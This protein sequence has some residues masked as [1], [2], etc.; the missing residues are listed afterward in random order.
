MSEHEKT[1][2]VGR[3]IEFGNS[4]LKRIHLSREADRFVSARELLACNI[5]DSH[6]QDLYNI[7]YADR[8]GL[9]TSSYI[10]TINGVSFLDKDEVQSEV[11]SIDDVPKYK[12]GDAQCTAERLLSVVQNNTLV[13]C[14]RIG[15]W[16]HSIDDD[17]FCQADLESLRVSCQIYQPVLT[18]GGSIA[19]Y[20]NQRDLDR[21]RCTSMKVGRAFKHMFQNMSDAQ[22][23]RLHDLWLD[24]TAPRTFSLRRGRSIEDFNIAYTADRVVSRNLASTRADYKSL[25]MS[26]MHDVTVSAIHEGVDVEY[27]P[28]S[29]YASGD[30]EIAYVVEED[31]DGDIESIAGR[32]IYSI[33]RKDEDGH[34]VEDKINAPVYAACEQ[35]GQMLRDHLSSIDCH[36]SSDLSEWS[37]LRLLKIEAA[38]HDTYIAPYLDGDVA[39]ELGRKHI[40]LDTFGSIDLNSTEGLLHEGTYCIVCDVHLA[41]DEAFYS[42]DGSMCDCCYH[43][44][45]GTCSESGEDHPVEDLIEVNYEYTGNRFCHKIVHID[46]ARYC[47]CV[48][49]WWYEDDV[50][51]SDDGDF[52]PTHRIDDF[53]E[54]FD[55]DKETQEE[56]A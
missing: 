45:Y 18:E 56:V 38:H 28:S 17:L 13:S 41:E 10:G 24:E 9:C 44:S 7:V 20:L 16:M 15:S 26:C 6:R 52:V 12:W 5:A 31:E 34:V 2:E 47:E 35:S 1:A 43:E 14:N 4:N 19:L 37:G 36:S 23:A 50:T 29:V 11:L 42:D 49:Q 46:Y 54:L 21:G 40:I 3:F 32:V 25:A 39:C 55:L 8:S 48:E 22:V 30:F 27:S 33:G 53:P 51:I